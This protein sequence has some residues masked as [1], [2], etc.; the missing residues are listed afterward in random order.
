MKQTVL[1]FMLLLTFLAGKAQLTPDLAAKL[2]AKTRISTQKNSPIRTGDITLYG[3]DVKVAGNDFAY[4]FPV[5]GIR[6]ALLVRATDG[7]QAMEWKT[8]PVPAGVQKGQFVNYIIPV[9]IGCNGPLFEMD[10]EING[11]SSFRIDN[12]DVEFWQQEDQAGRSLAFESIYVDGNR[13]RRGFFYLRIPA[14]QLPE[15]GN[16]LSIRITADKRGSQAWFMVFTD[17]ILPETKV[18]LS[19]AIIKG[20]QQLLLDIAHFGKPVNSTVKL[21]GKVIGQKQ[22]SMGNN[23]FSVTIDKVETPRNAV[24]EVITDGKSQTLPVSLKPS[25]NWE[26]F[27]VQHTH[28]DIGYTRPQNEILG[29]HIRY[30]DY[31]LDYCDQTDHLPAEAQFRWTCETSWAVE[32]FLETRPA[33]QIERLKRRIREG[34]IEVAGM[35]FNFSELPD[36]QAL[37]ASLSPLKACR[38]A[39]IPVEVAMQNDVNGIAWAYAD[40]FAQI[41]IRYLNMGTH[42]HRA[43]ICFDTPTVFRWQSPSGS[44]V[45]GY[46]AEHYNTGNFFGIEKD[47]FEEFEMKVL[48]YLIELEAKSYPY[49]LAAIQFSGYFTDNSP[50]SLIACK[51][52]E[53]WNKKYSYPKIRL[54]VSSEFL[55]R[56]EKEHY[57]ELPVLKQ[58][59]PDWW[60]DGFGAAAR[61]TAVNRYAKADMIVNSG[62]LSMAALKGAAIPEKTYGE[63]D[64]INRAILFYDEHTTGYS[65]SVRQPWCKSTMDQRALKESYAWEAYRKSRT[66]SETAAGLLQGYTQGARVPSIVVYNTLNFPRTGIAEAYIDHEILPLDREFEIVDATTGRSIEAQPMNSRADGTYWQLRVADIPPFGCKQYLINVSSRK[67][68]RELS[69]K[70]LPAEVE[71]DFYRIAFDARKGTIRSLVDKDL[72]QELI[73]SESGTTLGEFVYERLAERGSMEAFTMGA[74]TRQPLD[75]VWF[76]GVERGPIYDSYNFA[77]RTVAG[78]DTPASNFSASYRIHHQDKLIELCYSITKKTVI[79]PEGIYIALPFGLENSSIYCEVPGGVMQAGADQIKGSSNDWNTHQ[80]FVSV[81]NSKAQIIVGSAEAPLMQFGGINTGRYKAGALPESS[82][83]YS[84]VMNNYWVTNFNAE[85]RGEFSWKYSLTSRTN[86]SDTEASRFGWETRLPLPTRILA[87]DNQAPTVSSFVPEELLRI[88]GGDFLLVSA[89]PVAGERALLLHLREIGNKEAEVTVPGYTL[90]ACDVLGNELTDSSLKVLPLGV[91]FVKLLY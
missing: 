63:I 78:V 60:T 83:L 86:P 74:Y 54:S 24:V 6:N 13:D 46:R 9:A 31:A 61:E 10:V 29:E 39:E 91:K 35:I 12:R 5:K 75:T 43:L 87:P 80:N 21:D 55:K 30:I 79:E 4:S 66:L 70:E 3:V 26:M 18:C 41:G 7:T 17:K 48:N 56:I 69:V 76:T 49:D 42:G 16:P 1:I 37:V 90:K 72:S 62:L 33:E 77:A 25:R 44:E 53:Q 52:V 50:P 65:E 59:W 71:N 14:A 32:Q 51:H 64:Q 40:Y 27:F 23:S 45:I 57:A 36:E 84:W 8:V 68:V 2:E 34:R 19:P 67:R 22:L 38:K 85:Q 82:N 73:S 47:N 88:E 81:R 58:A 11:K 28:T 15:Q 89:T 20:R